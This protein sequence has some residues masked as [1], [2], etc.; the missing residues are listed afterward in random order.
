MLLFVTRCCILPHCLADYARLW[1]PQTP[2]KRH[3]WQSYSGKGEG[4]RTL[5]C[6]E[7]PKEGGDRS[8][9]EWLPMSKWRGENALG[10]W[11][12]PMPDTSIVIERVA[13]M[14]SFFFFFS[15]FLSPGWSGAHTHREQSPPEFEASVLDSKE[16]LH[17]PKPYFNSHR[18][19]DLF[20]LTQKH[21]FRKKRQFLSGMFWSAVL[22][23]ARVEWG[24]F[25]IS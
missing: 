2:G 12:K 15:S 9:S 18:S 22:T 11:G 6:H 7:D 20:S 25:L 17:I 8:K 1:I 14:L 10:V 21:P 19:S 13:Q 16:L 5:L 23:K 4:H 24:F 3:F